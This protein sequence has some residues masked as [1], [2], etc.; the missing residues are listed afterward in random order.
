MPDQF[1][2]V[3]IDLINHGFSRLDGDVREAVKFWVSGNWGWRRLNP[4]CLEIGAC[5]RIFQSSYGRFFNGVEILAPD[6]PM[7][8]W[9]GPQ[10]GR[11]AP[12]SMTLRLLAFA[13]AMMSASAW[14]V[15]ATNGT[16]KC[17]LSLL[18]Q[19]FTCFRSRFVQISLRFR[20][21]FVRPR[22]DPTKSIADSV[23]RYR[24][25]HIRYQPISGIR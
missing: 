17:P 18:K 16:R 3:W 9:Q 13:W 5:H 25:K 11:V 6:G 19:P 20:P 22:F 24:L 12:M 2:S 4:G 7:T 15:P 23:A 21:S 8:S 10:T 14:P 1:L